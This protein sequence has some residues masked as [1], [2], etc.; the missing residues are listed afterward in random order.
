MIWKINWLLVKY[1]VD[2]DGEPN[3]TYNEKIIA[4]CVT[5]LQRVGAYEIRQNIEDIFRDTYNANH[6]ND[7]NSI[8]W[9]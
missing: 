3:I 9:H 8:D 5:L 4:R 7:V 1:Y 2:A 6:V